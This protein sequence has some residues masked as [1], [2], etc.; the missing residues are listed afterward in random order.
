VPSFFSRFFRIGNG[1]FGGLP[2][3]AL[4]LTQKNAGGELRLGTMSMC[5]GTKR[6]KNSKL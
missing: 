3:D 4:A 1:L 6:T 2:A 5:V